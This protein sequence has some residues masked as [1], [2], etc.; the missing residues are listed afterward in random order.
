MDNNKVN[1]LTEKIAD[2]LMERCPMLDDM[3]CTELAKAILDEVE[4]TIGRIKNE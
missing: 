4:L 3:E 1:Y 2:L